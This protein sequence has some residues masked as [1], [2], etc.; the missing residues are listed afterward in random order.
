MRLENVDGLRAGIGPGRRPEPVSTNAYHQSLRDINKGCMVSLPTLAFS[1]YIY[2]P[3]Y[4][5]N[6]CDAVRAAAFVIGHVNHAAQ[7]AS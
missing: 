4:N 1:Q 6:T 5:C 7:A 3:T 2:N